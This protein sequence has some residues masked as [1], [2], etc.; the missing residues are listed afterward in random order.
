VYR[1]RKERVLT[2]ESN[3]K[4]KP[5]DAKVSKGYIL[6]TSSIPAGADYWLINICESVGQFWVPRHEI[7]VSVNPGVTDIDLQRE[8]AA[9]LDE[10]KRYKFRITFTDGKVPPS[11]IPASEWV[12]A[13][14]SEVDPTPASAAN[15]TASAPSFWEQNGKKLITVIAI[16]AVLLPI[17]FYAIY[18]GNRTVGRSE[19]D[20]T[21]ADQT[22]TTPA[23]TS[24]ISTQL[25]EQKIVIDGLVAQIET[26]EKSNA[27]PV[28]APA[29]RMPADIKTN[30]VASG[31]N[32]VLDTTSG[33]LVLGVNGNQNTIN[34]NNDNRSGTFYGADGNGHERLK[35]LPKGMPSH[36]SITNNMGIFEQVPKSSGV[37]N[38]TY[39]VQPGNGMM[40]L[41]TP[42]WKMEIMNIEYSRHYEH[43]VWVEVGTV[44]KPMWIPVP[45]KD[46]IKPNAWWV[47]SYKDTLI[48]QVRLTP[49]I[50]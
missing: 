39:T 9:K 47:Q 33:K 7:T 36:A 10:K 48:V 24:E 16:L 44:D 38:M 4:M 3:S 42:G 20:G 41:T 49:R 21:G 26:L 11:S 37:Q 22:N 27:A 14:S 34:I 50:E 25:A 18:K 32:I 43:N 35:G 6:S 19:V 12:V 46:E 15:S 29:P 30:I 2:T 23:V 45:E 28:V 5:V 17:T 40:F 8:I 31:T 13:D 1:W